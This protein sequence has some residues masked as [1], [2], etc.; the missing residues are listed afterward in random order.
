M[1]ALL[2]PH[3]GRE[4]EFGDQIAAPVPVAADEFAAMV[5]R[6]VAELEPGLTALLAGVPVEAGDLPA[7]EDLTAVDPPFAPT[8][9]GLCRG[10]P[11]GAA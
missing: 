4:Q 5:R 10:A 7:L 8:I 6:A 2:A 1:A 3:E 9:L 11:R